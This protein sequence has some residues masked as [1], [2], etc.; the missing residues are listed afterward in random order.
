MLYFHARFCIG[1]A[2]R[3]VPLALHTSLARIVWI[4]ETESRVCALRTVC[5]IPPHFTGVCYSSHCS[6]SFNHTILIHLSYVFCYFW[7][8]ILVRPSAAAAPLSPLFFPLLRSLSLQALAGDLTVL[9]QSASSVRPAPGHLSKTGG[10]VSRWSRPSQDDANNTNRWPLKLVAHCRRHGRRP[11]PPRTSN[12]ASKQS[13]KRCLTPTHNS[14]AC[15]ISVVWLSR[16]LA[17]A[18]GR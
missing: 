7:I 8:P 16:P 14:P 2:Y 10:R 11:C 12:K 18:S 5:P 15:L 9:S 17:R 13:N 3:C 1:R 4:C 6:F